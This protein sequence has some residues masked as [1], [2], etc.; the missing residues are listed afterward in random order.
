MAVDVD[1]E[2]LA[3]LSEKAVGRVDCLEAD[4]SRWTACEQVVSE[5]VARHGRVDVLVNCAAILRRTELDEVN[6]ETFAAIFD[7]NCRAVFVLMR[8]AMRDMERRGWGRIVNVTSVGVHVGGY[9]LTSA[10][11]EASK[12]AVMSFT[13]TFARYAGPC[14]ILV[15]AVAPGGMRTPMLTEQT[16]PELL[17]FVEQDIPLGRLAEPGEV[18]GLIVYLASEENT[19]ASGATFDVNGG[20]VTP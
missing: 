11:Y 3:A 20:V 17:Q 6:P 12:A 7:A 16:P 9:S 1:V 4:L 10:L 19:Y 5:T 13:K 18:A 8:Q 14:G 15:N 2:G